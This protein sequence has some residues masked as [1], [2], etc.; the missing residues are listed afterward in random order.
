MAEGGFSVSGLSAAILSADRLHVTL[1]VSV[2][3]GTQKPLIV[4]TVNGND[5]VLIDTNGFGGDV[6]PSTGL[7]INLGAGEDTIDFVDSQTANTW[8]FAGKQSGRVAVGKF[9]SFT[10]SGL[11]HASGGDGKDTFRITNTGENGVLSLAGDGGTLDTLE[12]KRDANI[13]LSNTKLV[14][15]PLATGQLHQTFTLQNLQLAKLT[16][17]NGH[18][19][20]NATG[21][22]GNVTLT[23]LAGNDR[24]LGGSG[25]DMLSG[26]EG[27][28]WISG[29]GGNDTLNGGNGRDILVG[30]LGSDRLNQAGFAADDDILLGG[31]TNFDTN[32]TA[33]AA[34]VL[35]WS[36]NSSFADRVTAITTTGVGANKYR[37]NAN[38]VKDD[39]SLDQYL[40][41]SGNDWF[42][43]QL[44]AGT[45]LEKPDESTLERSFMVDV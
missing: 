20:L 30:G 2:I 16:G 33:M 7:T 40:G 45:G 25:N 29:G 12:I 24:L 23:G 42:F 27:H 13:T 44:T 9:G 34:F 36:D 10:F 4:N 39:N 21:F 35:A 14:V 17:G 6:I 3:E 37:L 41:G 28:D 19:T 15:D 31:T 26:G 8:T 18:N 43:A 5:S 11:E 22:T 32:S 1:P 38:T